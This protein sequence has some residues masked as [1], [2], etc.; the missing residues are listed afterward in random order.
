AIAYGDPVMF[1][2]SPGVGKSAFLK[3]MAELAGIKA[4]VINLPN[5][6]PEDLV[7]VMPKKITGADAKPKTVLGFMLYKELMD[8]SPKIL[9][10]EEPSRAMGQ[11][12][13]MALELIQELRIADIP[14]PNVLGVFAAD[15]VSAED[16][17]TKQAD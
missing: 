11:V 16:G 2:G 3:A 4:V 7:L 13:N 10:L 15:N 14:V 1:K 12:Q 5:C 9:V 6:A 8:P 17:I